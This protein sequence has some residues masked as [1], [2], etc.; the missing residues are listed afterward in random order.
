[1]FSILAHILNNQIVLLRFVQKSQNKKDKKLTE[2]IICQT[3]IAR[4]ETM[5]HAKEMLRR[6]EKESKK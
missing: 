1:M 4:D 2:E 3:K 5:R 6:H